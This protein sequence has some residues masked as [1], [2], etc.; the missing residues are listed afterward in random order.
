MSW[1]QLLK[2]SGP[3]TGH[4]Q[5]KLHKYFRKWEKKKVDVGPI[6]VLLGCEKVIVNRKKRKAMPEKKGESNNDNS[7][8][9]FSPH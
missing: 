4:T 1:S 6:I 8:I 3:P 7:N 5:Q 9:T 2:Y